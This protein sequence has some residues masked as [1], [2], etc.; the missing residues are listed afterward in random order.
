MFSHGRFGSWV[1][2]PRLKPSC[3][4]LQHESNI[5]Y[6]FA[7]HR[8]VVKKCH[9]SSQRDIIHGRYLGLRFLVWVSHFGMGLVQYGPPSTHRLNLLKNI[10][11]GDPFSQ[12]KYVANK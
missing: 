9:L 5:R 8:S 7:Q 3:T 12:L 10:N 6:P 4:S 11:V 1:L 2:N